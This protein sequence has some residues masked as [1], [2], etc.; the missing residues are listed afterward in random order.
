MSED[1]TT[2]WTRLEDGSYQSSDERAT[3]IKGSSHWE[4]EVE[5]ANFRKADFGTLKAAQEWYDSAPAP[6]GPNET[7]ESNMPTRTRQRLGRIATALHEINNEVFGD[8]ISEL[9][10]LA[11]HDGDLTSEEVTAYEQ[12]A[13]SVSVAD[14]EKIVRD[15]NAVS[16]RVAQRLANVVEGDE[17]DERIQSRL[18][19]DAFRLE[20]LLGQ[21]QPSEKEKAEEAEAS[22]DEEE[23]IEAS[24]ADEA[25]EAEESEDSSDLAGVFDA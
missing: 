5:K 14:Q 9:Q 2:E 6:V 4:L 1:T 24:S 7:E 23:I 18:Y 10:K 20:K 13:S 19:G 15:A 22:S 25:D 8:V 12:V 17:T 3:I 11:T 16:V 21:H